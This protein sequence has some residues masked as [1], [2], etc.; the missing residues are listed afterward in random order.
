[1][2]GFGRIDRKFHQHPKVQGVSLSAIGLWTLAN[3]WS[4][5]QRSKGFIP[6]DCPLL[7]TADGEVVELCRA[8][9]WD[10]V[11][12]GYHFHDYEQWNGDACA[13]TVLSRLMATLADHPVVVQD[14]MRE[15]I[16]ELL[17]DGQKPVHIEAALKVWAERPANSINFLP[18][19][20][21]DEI[22]RASEGEFKQLCRDCWKSGD[23]TPLRRHGHWFRPPL[24]PLE[25]KTVDEMRKFML[26]AKRRWIESIQEGM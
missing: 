17:E 22:K 26:A 18:Y 13:D 7:D 9:L 19:L 1:M 2:A 25:I 4:R 8:G 20:V 3:A 6:V 12:G 10:S 23:V 14:K 16:V 21:S 5:D 15:K 24:A 11:P